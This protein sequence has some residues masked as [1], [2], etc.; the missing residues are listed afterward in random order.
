VNH[1][2]PGNAF[3]SSMTTVFFRWRICSG[4]PG[5]C[6]MVVGGANDL[7]EKSRVSDDDDQTDRIAS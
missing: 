2:A 7:K 3:G 6:V 4:V 5:D 1:D